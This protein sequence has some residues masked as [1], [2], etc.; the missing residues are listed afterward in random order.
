MRKQDTMSVGA[1]SLWKDN[2]KGVNSMLTSKLRDTRH[3]QCLRMIRGTSFKSSKL[4][5]A[6]EFAEKGKLRKAELI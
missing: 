2:S 3:K 4:A 6:P 1:Q 5:V